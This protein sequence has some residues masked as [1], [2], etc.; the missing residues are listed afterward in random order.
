MK[1][2]TAAA[3]LVATL[4]GSIATAMAA[5]AVTTG[6]A[7]VRQGGSTSAPVITSLPGGASVDATCYDQGWCQVSGTGIYR[8]VSG[9]IS[10][11]LIAF[12]DAQRPPAPGPGPQPPA[13]G[14]GPQ[15]QPPGPGTGGGN[16]GPGFSFDFNWGT[17]QPQ[18]PRPQPGYQQAG[19]C[20][21]SERNFR[22]S[23]FC[24]SVGD[25]YERMPRGW[26]DVVRSVQVYGRARVDLCSDTGF[27]GNCVT[28]RSDQSRLPSGIDRRIS[29]VDVY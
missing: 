4:L 17:P 16:S 7:N 5:P 12:T 22:G 14:P 2:V 1:P 6:S 27:Y 19:A 21:F 8:G 10:G 23:S 29:S 20:F 3:V 25:S 28:V 24:L 26:N 15:P 13:P 11:S 18:W 9:W